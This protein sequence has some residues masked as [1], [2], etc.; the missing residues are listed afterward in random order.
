MSY[1]VQSI[2]FWEFLEDKFSVIIV[3][4]LSDITMAITSG[5]CSQI[6]NKLAFAMPFFGLGYKSRCRYSLLHGQR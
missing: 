3:T 6:G 2:L 4:K 5:V 1:K